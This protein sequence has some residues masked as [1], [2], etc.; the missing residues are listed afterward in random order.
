M[1]NVLLMLWFTAS[2]CW[3]A[4]AQDSKASLKEAIRKIPGGKGERFFQAMS[5][6]GMTL[7]LYSPKGN[8][9]QKPHKRDEVYIIAKGS[10][11]FF[12]GLKTYDFIAGDAL[13]VSA[14][15]E[16]RFESF[17]EDFVTW[18]VFYGPEK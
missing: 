15:V 2:I 5:K 1:K 4:Y 9:D 12:D 6:E 14:G 13:Y 17:S 10:G 16:H 18:V 8:D 7:L 11:R 3:T